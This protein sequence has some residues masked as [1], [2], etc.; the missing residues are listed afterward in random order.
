MGSLFNELAPQIQDSGLAGTAKQQGQTLINNSASSQ[1]E[2]WLTGSGGKAKVNIESGLNESQ[3]N[4][5]LDY[6][7]PWRENPSSTLFSQ[8]GTQRWN[9]RN[10]IN[11]GFGYR[12]NI[13]AE[14]ILG[15]NVFLDLDATRHHS[16][17]GSGIEIWNEQLRTAVNY[18]QPLSGW[19]K[20]HDD[21]F[22]DDTFRF[23]LYERAAKGWDLNLKSGLSQ[24]TSA[25]ATFFQWYG[26]KVDV[27]GTRNDASRNPY[28]LTLGVN[29]Q[30]VSLVGFNV[31]H[32]QISDQ[33]GE[34]NAGLSFNWDFGRSF[35]QQMD[36]S[37]ASAL[38]SLMHSRHDF[39]TRNNNIVLAYKQQNKLQ[40][41]YFDPLEASVKALGGE[42]INAVK[43]GN[44]G[45]ISYASSNPLL[46]E[47]DPASGRVKPLKHGNVQISAYEFAR[48]DSQVPIGTARYSLEILPADVAPSAQNVSISGEAKVGSVISGH[49]DFVTHEGADEHPE[50]SEIS[51]YRS[52]DLSTAISH[53]ADYTLTN[54]D[55]DHRLIFQVIP[56]NAA[57]IKGVAEQ[58]EIAAPTTTLQ[59][60]FLLPVNGVEQADKSIKFPQGT[61]GSIEA[62]VRVVDENSAPI[63]NVTVHWREQ[64]DALGSLSQQTSL[65]DAQGYASVHYNNIQQ[66]GAA[67]LTASL[68]EPATFAAT[69]AHG[70]NERASQN[71]AS[72]NRVSKKE[73]KARF[74]QPKAVT[75]T[76]PQTE[77]VIGSGKM[78]FTVNVTDE[79]GEG[80]ASTIIWSA[81]GKIVAESA[82]DLHGVSVYSFDIPTNVA[83]SESWTITAAVK[84]ET[85]NA[86]ITLKL[87]RQ[88]SPLLE[89]LEDIVGEFAP[90]KPKTKFLVKGG[91]GG[92]LQLSSDNPNTAM[93]AASGDGGELTFLA[94]GS[95]KITV[96]QAA[97]EIFASPEAVTFNV[98]VTSGPIYNLYLS[99]EDKQPEADGRSALT[100]SVIAKDVFDNPLSEKQIS[101]SSPNVTFSSA[102]SLTNKEGKAEV[103]ITSVV[104]GKH[105]ITATAAGVIR[106]KDVLFKGVPEVKNVAIS[107]KLI[108]GERLTVT[109]QFMENGTGKEKE[110]SIHWFSR[111][112]D[113]I[114]GIYQ[115]SQKTYRLNA[116][117][118]GAQIWV[119][120]IP[121]NVAGMAGTLQ[122]SELTAPIIGLPVA[123]N[124]QLTGTPKVGQ[125]LTLSY[126]YDG[127]GGGAETTTDIKWFKTPQGKAGAT[128]IG[129]GA[130]YLLQPADLKH[131]VYAEVTPVSASGLK[132]KLVQSSSLMIFI[133]PS[134]GLLEVKKDRLEVGYTVA[135]SYVYAAHGGAAESGSTIQWMRHAKG[136]K[137]PIAG[138]TQKSYLL[139]REDIGTSVSFTVTPRNSDGMEGEVKSSSSQ[140]YVQPAVAAS[141]QLNSH[142]SELL[143]AGEPVI[144]TATVKNALDKPVVGEVVRWSSALN[145]V[146]FDENETLTD[147]QG[148]ATVAVQAS[149]KYK[150]F[151]DQVTAQASSNKSARDETEIFFIDAIPRIKS[152]AFTGTFKVGEKVGIDLVYDGNESAQYMPHYQWKL[153]GNA[154]PKATGQFLTLDKP[155]FADQALTVD[156]TL[157]NWSFNK[158]VSK[159]QSFKAPAIQN[160]LQYEITQLRYNYVQLG[161][162]GA[163]YTVEVKLADQHE[164]PSKPAIRVCFRVAGERTPTRYYSV[165]T[166]TN[167]SHAS[168]THEGASFATLN[169]HAIV[170]DNH[171][172]NDK[173]FFDDG[174]VKDMDIGSKNVW[175]DWL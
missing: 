82:T 41:I 136:N 117:D 166:E 7:Y 164:E 151:N 157:V 125:T 9:E 109:Y 146:I 22:N 81:N 71:R 91:N 24:H 21:M 132:G 143:I 145:L 48:A 121:K 101:W 160:D 52:D 174:R 169:I 66:E 168:F 111:I 62:K 163:K 59:E 58:A 89:A 70:L 54:A 123:R 98:T 154:L 26:D 159:T 93:V 127:R 87:L 108:Q 172:S 12:K 42:Y 148:R 150:D 171:L 124:L 133:P 100:F 38:T 50:G 72:I 16:R 155:A 106:S 30:P 15:G 43:G 20:S 53:V 69:S 39:V 2:N 65:S 25:E 67:T 56:V 84:G 44:G 137:T 96:S 141:L 33:K 28:G 128:L 156:I 4:Y 139:T 105:L 165:K 34:W 60:L 37:Q 10:I 75:L 17:I 19:K 61:L 86:S 126:E 46:A 14:F 63:A 80:I 130:T 120:V 23:Q 49:Y 88:A 79:E 40:R 153:N 32:S 55:L 173:P 142:K 167:T 97:T 68:D 107:G 47:I 135:A 170:C 138:A 77:V 8:L 110:S 6:L 129:K 152:H 64:S 90:D 92:P 102:T 144:L 114:E 85:Q 122:K 94:K 76:S 5:G 3:W 13:T 103:Q 118:V 134:A 162:S 57:G 104:A 45:N 115:S 95:A 29:W 140:G 31:K 112:G 99:A 18:Y 73:L 158:Y 78:D 113:K 11:L 27:L 35:T 116:A 175:L 119:E 83:T 51:W 1:I 149:K 147:Q 161:V 74:S 36:P 131:S